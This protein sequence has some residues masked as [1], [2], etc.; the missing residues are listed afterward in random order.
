MDRVKPVKPNI[1]KAENNDKLAREALDQFINAAQNAI[2]NNGV[3]YVAISGGHTP[4]AF[5]EL[6]SDES[7]YSQVDWQKV[8]LFWV[9]ERCVLPSAD[10]SNFGQAANAFLLNVPIPGENI[11]RVSGEST[12]YEAAAKEY[13]QVIFRVFGIQPGQI[14]QFDLIILG[15]GADAHIGSLLPNSTALFETRHLVCTVY[16]MDDNHSRIT[17][18][19]PVIQQA[20]KILILVAGE[21]KAQIVHEVFSSEPDEVKYPVH[22]LWQNLDKITWIMDHQAAALL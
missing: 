8:H 12:D 16:R 17:L 4:T 11:H 2:R 13:E 22:Y 21:A 20:S 9:D 18:T 6:L 1:I 3:F 5:Y 7:A 15:M 14:P 10:A 19:V